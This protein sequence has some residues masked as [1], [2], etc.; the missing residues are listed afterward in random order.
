[1]FVVVAK[2]FTLLL[3][4][5]W[6]VLFHSFSLWLYSTYIITTQSSLWESSRIRRVFVFFLFRVVFNNV[7]VYIAGLYRISRNRFADSRLCSVVV[8]CYFHI[9]NYYS[10]FHYDFILY[11]S[12]NDERMLLLY[13]NKKKTTTTTSVFRFSWWILWIG[14]CDQNRR[15]RE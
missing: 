9:K 14:C 15:W 6:F 13:E 10:L 12:M 1:M 4:L 11:L 8:I 3:L 5:G 2:K 7:C